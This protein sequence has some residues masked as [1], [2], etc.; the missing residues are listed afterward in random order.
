MNVANAK[1]AS[2]FYRS[3]F[4]FNE[5]AYSGP[6][7]GNEEFVSYVL[8]QNKIFFV[9]TAAL[10]D[11]HMISKWVH[12]HGDGVSEIA[13]FSDSVINDYEYAVNNGAF[14][15]NDYIELHDSSGIYKI[16]SVNTYGDVIHA[17]VDDREYNGIWKPGY[18]SS[19][20]AIDNISTNKTDLLLVDHIVGNV[21]N[22]KMNHWANYYE[23]SFN[24]KSFIE[25]TEDDIA[26]KYSALRSKVMKSDTLSQINV[27]WRLAPIG[28]HIDALLVFLQ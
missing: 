25:F 9:I 2:H 23:K 27:Y 10:S 26:T 8:N 20:K 4:G 18:I 24:F 22:N 7:T 5:Y 11:D 15:N 21:E 3:V 12:K 13:F 14:S 1:Q 6:E 17:F 28:L 16:A 19:A